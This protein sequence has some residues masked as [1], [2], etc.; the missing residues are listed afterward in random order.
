MPTQSTSPNERD[1]LEMPRIQRL[2]YGFFFAVVVVGAT[3]ILDMVV[4][5]DLGSV[6]FSPLFIGLVVA[7]GYLVAPWFK[8]ALPF[9]PW[10]KP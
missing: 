5:E 8:R 7:I 1:S 2:R 10:R 9:A 3:M 6:I 4:R